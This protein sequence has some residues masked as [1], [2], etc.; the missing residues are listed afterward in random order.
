MN[1]RERNDAEMAQ[2]TDDEL[3]AHIAAARAA[4][5]DESAVMAVQILAYRH[6]RAVLA[7]I[8][9]ELG[10]RGPQAVEE[11]VERTI[12]DAIHSAA[13]FEGVVIEEFRGWLFRIA[14]RRRA[15]YLR[16]KRVK[17]V[18]MTRGGEDGEEREFGEGDP[19]DAVDRASVFKQALSELQKDSHK[20]V[21]FLHFF[22]DLP[23]KEITD[24][25]NRHFA[26]SS[27]D[28]MTDQ[29]VKQINS[30]FRKRLDELLDEADEPP[31]PDDDD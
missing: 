19:L 15:D 14:R 21:V 29:N 30:R 28:P 20:L 18:P 13:S 2:M 8:Q 10:S 11:V 31:R 26:G 22:H 3:I 7:F 5:R 12:V 6:E 9:K 23:A 27:D 24:Q 25:V 4:G 1:F 16:K 17:E